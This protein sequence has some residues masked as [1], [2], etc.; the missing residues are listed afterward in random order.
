M[1]SLKKKSYA[2]I[3]GHGYIGS[4]LCNY[5]LKKKINV[6]LKIKKKLKK[7]NNFSY[8]NIN[9]INSIELNK[10]LKNYNIKYIINSFGHIDHSK[11]FMPN[12]TKIFQEH[13]LVT[14]NLADLAINKKVK[15]FIQIG[16]ADEYGV[17]KNNVN[18]L[19][20]E[21]PSTPYGFYK[22]ISTKYLC[23]LKNEK[24]LNS[25]ILRLFTTY[26]P[27]QSIDRFIPYVINQS[28]M[29]KEFDLTDC[30]QYRDFIHIDDL[31]SIIHKVMISK[32]ILNNIILNV[33]TSKKT[34]LRKIVEF[35]I[36]YVGKGKPLYGKIK[37]SSKNYNKELIANNKKLLSYIGKYKFKELLKE[38]PKII[39]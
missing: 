6:L 4:N 35:I 38:I 22:L 27:D 3:C 9:P 10:S 34:Q 15:K 29:N 39:D 8:L 11:F 13:F 28:K 16:S 30:K 7:K 1:A 25:I 37:Y 18:E 5:F 32:K 17:V 23:A 36:N 24:L 20:K 12:E 33:G 31:V 19:S 21:N 26:G 2:L 14:K